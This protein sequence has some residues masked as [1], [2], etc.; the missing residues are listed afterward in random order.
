MVSTYTIPRTTFHPSRFCLK[1]GMD[2]ISRK[3]LWVMHSLKGGKTKGSL[4]EKE[5]ARS[6]LKGHRN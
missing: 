3:P 1:R 5:R 2:S 4:W 6:K